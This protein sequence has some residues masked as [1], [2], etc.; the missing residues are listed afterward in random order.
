MKT[1]FTELTEE[2]QNIMEE[3]NLAIDFMESLHP[4]NKG[5]MS[6]LEEYIAK[7]NKQLGYD[8]SAN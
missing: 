4:S 6:E 5:L 1:L 3:R 8:D 7:L 2:E